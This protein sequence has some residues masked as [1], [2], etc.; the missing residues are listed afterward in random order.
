[1]TPAPYRCLLLVVK[2]KPISI[3]LAAILVLTSPRI[4]CAQENDEFENSTAV[5][6]DVLIARPACLGATAI[7]TIAFILS[8]PIAAACGNV[9]KSAHSLIVVPARQTFVR[10]LGDFTAME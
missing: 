3:T 5:I 7:G 8:L 2:A 10:K 9:Q 6:T 1:M 4:A